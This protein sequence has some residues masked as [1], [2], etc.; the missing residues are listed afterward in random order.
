MG[1]GESR[2]SDDHRVKEEDKVLTTGNP[3]AKE[4]IFR[5]EAWISFI[6]IREGICEVVEALMDTPVTPPLYTLT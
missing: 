4:A 6:D 1:G 3:S 5:S 2:T